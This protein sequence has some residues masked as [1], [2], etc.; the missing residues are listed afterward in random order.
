MTIDD[1]IATLE[2]KVWCQDVI[3]YELTSALQ[4]LKQDQGRSLYDEVRESFS[5]RLASMLLLT[6][7]ETPNIA[8]AQMWLFHLDPDDPL[9][10]TE[11]LVSSAPP[12]HAAL[13]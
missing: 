11:I 7:H 12:S 9:D 4:R 10:V 2:R 13:N 8:P 6:G 1:R 5:H 3:I